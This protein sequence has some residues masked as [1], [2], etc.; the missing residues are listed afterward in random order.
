[1]RKGVPEQGGTVSIG[2]LAIHGGGGQVA[3]QALDHRRHLRRRTGLGLGIDT[4]PAFFDVP[5]HHDPRA[6]IA[7]VPLGH[8]MGLLR[9]AKPG[10][11]RSLIR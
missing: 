5:I 9:C 4:D 11:A 2:V 3:Q 6:S 1:M 7:L 10:Q 8:Q